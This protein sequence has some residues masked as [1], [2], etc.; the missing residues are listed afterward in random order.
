MTKRL[1]IIIIVLL[2]IA[3]LAFI[4]DAGPGVD[5]EPTATAKVLHTATVKAYPGPAV[6]A[7]FAPTETP[8]ISILETTE[9]TATPGFAGLRWVGPTPTSPVQPYPTAT[10]ES[11]P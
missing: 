11:Y 2:L 5:A 4:P 7:T 6:S 1:W 3:A 8:V 9:P 10:V